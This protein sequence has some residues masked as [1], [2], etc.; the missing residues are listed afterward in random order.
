MDD[1]YNVQPDSLRGIWNLRGINNVWHWNILAVPV[2]KK[3]KEK[4]EWWE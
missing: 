3:E 1:S 4:R 2:D